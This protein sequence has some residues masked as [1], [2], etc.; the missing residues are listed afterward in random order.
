[1]QSNIFTSTRLHINSQQRPKGMQTLSHKTQWN[2]LW[3]VSAILRS[4]AHLETLTCA[5]GSSAAEGSVRARSPPSGTGNTAVCRLGGCRRASRNG[6]MVEVRGHAVH[7]VLALRRVAVF[8]T[9]RDVV[10][11]VTPSRL[12]GTA[13]LL[14]PSSRSWLKA[15]QSVVAGTRSASPWQ[16]ASL[17]FCSL[18]RA[19]T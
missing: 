13:V 3:W 10:S 17:F 4:P 18:Q 1:M 12:A 7:H 19:F 5:H 2:Q 9:A 14:S 15:I 16:G 11:A 6:S 8:A